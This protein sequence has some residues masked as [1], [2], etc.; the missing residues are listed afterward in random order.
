MGRM[1]SAMRVLTLSGWGQPHDALGVLA[2]GATHVD[3]ARCAGV[4]EALAEL[5]EEGRGH[6][7]VIGW[8]LGGQLAVRAVAAGMLRPAALVLIAAPFRFVATPQQPIGMKRDLYDKFRANYARH[9]ERTL[10]KAWELVVK[11]DGRAEQVRAHLGKQDRLAVLEKDWLG[12]FDRLDGFGCEE[13]PMEH[14]PSTLLIHGER[15][16]VV[17]V[18]Q[19]RCFA[20]ALPQAR[21]EI[22]SQCG[23]A[24]HW[25]DSEYVQRL[26]EE[27][28]HV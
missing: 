19:S 5:A 13:L 18:E 4:E 8:S 21:L 16:V 27:H 22:L 7:V 28:G 17:N 12:W 1:V 25:H 24:P 3:Y 14:F 23:H 2:P 11:D 9:S 26:I 6:D 20:A 10:E 15:D